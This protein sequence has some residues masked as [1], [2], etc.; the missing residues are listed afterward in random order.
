MSQDTLIHDS[1]MTLRRIGVR[2]PETFDDTQAVIRN[3]Y[4]LKAIV[5]HMGP[6][7]EGTGGHFGRP[8]VPHRDKYGFER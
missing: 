6:I 1:I 2:C 8:V 5:D 3:I 7:D 4:K